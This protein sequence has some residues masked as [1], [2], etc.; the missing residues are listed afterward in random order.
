MGYITQA[1]LETAFGAT[2][3][4]DL[5]DRAGDG[6]AD[7]AV[8]TAAI[9]R[10]GGLVDSYLQSRFAVPLPETPQLV[11]EIMLALVRYQLSEDHATDRVK[12]DYERALRWL[13]E[14]RDGKMDI[15][16]A[17]IGGPA[18]STTGGAQ[19]S[20]GRSAFDD[21]LLDAYAGTQG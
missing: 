16:V 20:E 19:I 10:A 17:P 12:E 15:G 7:T 6:F 21:A 18:Q 11:G 1:D 9:D 2:E 8:I 3:V 4:I 13:G 14:A 5:A